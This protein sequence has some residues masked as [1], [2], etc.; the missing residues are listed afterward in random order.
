MPGYKITHRTTYD[1]A[2]PVVQSRHLLYLTPRQTPQ[3]TRARNSLLVEPAPTSKVEQLDYFGNAAVHIALERDHTRFTAT[4][5]SE[6]AV[7]ATP[8]ID[9]KAT[10]PWREVANRRVDRVRGFDRSIIDFTAFSP[11]A[12]PTLDIR[13]F[14]EE[15]LPADAPILVAAQALMS[16]IHDEFRYDPTST[17]ISTP[18]VQVLEQRSG[19][20]QDFA[21]IGIAALRALGLPARYVSGY[22]RTHPPEG[23]ERLIGADAS[24]AW[25]SV[26]APETGWVDFDPTNNLVQSDDHVTVAYGRD[27]ADVSPISGVLLGGGDHTVSVS[28]DVAPMDEPKSPAA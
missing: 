18:V 11:L 19:V 6:V 20:C 21:H 8:K 3:Q 7:S 2:A 27:F 13:R 10:S 28:V 26:W 4:A 16:R 12:T 25:F 5:Q 1:Y 24:H 15:T 14:A 17:D 23:K 9:F 22:I